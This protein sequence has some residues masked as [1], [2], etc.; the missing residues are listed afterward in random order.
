VLH[1]VCID[2]VLMEEFGVAHFQGVKR[3]L[4]VEILIRKTLAGWLGIGRHGSTA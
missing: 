2:D 4:V 1:C 3:K